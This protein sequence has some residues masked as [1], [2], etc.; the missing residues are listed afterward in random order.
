MVN[1]ARGK[2]GGLLRFPGT[3]CSILREETDLIPTFDGLLM[4]RIR[5]DFEESLK[6]VVWKEKQ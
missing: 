4:W 3:F 1:A 2:Y 6:S 5:V